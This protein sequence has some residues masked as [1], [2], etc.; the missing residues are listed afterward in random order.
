MSTLAAPS[1]WS[2]QAAGSNLIVHAAALFGGAIRR[3]L[4][5]WSDQRR[6]QALPDYLLDDLGI[7][8]REIG[9][10]TEFGRVNRF[11]PSYRV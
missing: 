6:I 5:T 4:K 2:R 11:E 1:R 8:R 7:S 9:S 10:A 3:Q